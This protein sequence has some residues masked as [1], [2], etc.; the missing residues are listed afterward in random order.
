M[1]RTDKSA[2]FEKKKSVHGAG[3]WGV[4]VVAAVGGVLGVCLAC[5]GGGSKA[6]WCPP[7]D[8]VFFF[9]W[10]LTFACAL[11]TGVL[12]CNPNMKLASNWCLTFAPT[13][14]GV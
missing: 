6:A 7:Q 5:A 2:H 14:S 9:Y 11:K 13:T 8:P 1:S 3:G 4:V 12:V 10:R